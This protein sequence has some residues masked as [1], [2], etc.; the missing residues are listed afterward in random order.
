[1]SGFS[2]DAEWPVVE[3]EL[4]PASPRQQHG[5]NTLRRR[6]RRRWPGD[7]ARQFTHPLALLLWLAAGL[8][9]IVE[10]NV[11]AA[12]VILIIGLNAVFSF[13][14]ELQAERAV[15]RETGAVSTSRG[16]RDA[17]S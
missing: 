8:L 16:S 15:E 12:A 11:V 10:S 2:T 6:H 3:A 1:M 13:A 17:L 9:L 4:C 5:P 14:R 7:L